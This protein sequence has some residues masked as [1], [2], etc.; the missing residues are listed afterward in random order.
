MPFLNDLSPAAGVLP[1][2]A[3]S[4]HSPAIHADY[5]ML[6]SG[7][8]APPPPPPMKKPVIE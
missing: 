6:A 3:E 8:A 2:Y 7:I 4:V 1:V 5:V